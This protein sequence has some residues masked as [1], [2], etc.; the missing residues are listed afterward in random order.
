[1]TSKSARRCCGA[2]EKTTEYVYG[3]AFIIRKCP[4]ILPVDIDDELNVTRDDGEETT[5][6][7]H[8]A[9]TVNEEET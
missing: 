2:A 6:D 7:G 5:Y 4:N 9:S 1:M 8:V 3:S